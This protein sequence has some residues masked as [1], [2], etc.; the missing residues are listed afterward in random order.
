MF[1]IKSLLVVASV[2]LSAVL[3]INTAF[4]GMAEH[5]TKVDDG[6][7]AYGDPAAGYTSMFVVTNDGVIVMEP[8]NTKHSTAMLK[9]IRS[10]T[11]Q[12]IRY[13]IHSHNHWDHSGG[14]QVFRDAGATIVA[15]VEA[16]EWMKAN[17]N[18]DMA[19][20]DESWAGNRKDILLG[21]TTIEL[22]YLGMNHGLGMTVFRLPREKIVFIADIVTP[23]RLLFTIVPDFNIKPWLRS[24]RE[25]EA[26]DFQTA[27]F[28]HG[29]T[30][31]SK[32]DVTAN[33][34]FIEDLRSAIH[35][36]F[37]KGTNPF[38]IPNLVRVPKYQGWAMYDEWLAMNA[39]RLLL[40]DYMGPFPWRPDHSYEA[41]Q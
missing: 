26:M 29:K 8:I 27:V 34:E 14:G 39:W 23:D 28:T 35:A 13:L 19:L 9:A 25:I 5:I 41:N 30:V 21:G 10:V 3:M 17:P 37:K 20:P 40:D 6:V 24:L 15:H 7:Y 11:D 33:R 1:N 16:Y 2:M 32:K 22:H 12:P 18:K 36:E 4:A 31:G 38:E